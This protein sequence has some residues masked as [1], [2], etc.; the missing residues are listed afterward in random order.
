[1]GPG[2]RVENRSARRPKGKRKRGFVFDSNVKNVFTRHISCDSR[3]WRVCEV[4]SQSRQSRRIYN[5]R[6]Q[7]HMKDKELAD[8]F[9]FE[10]Q[11]SLSSKR[12]K[13]LFTSKFQQR[14]REGFHLWVLGSFFYN[15]EHKDTFEE[16]HDM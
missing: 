2:G 11:S 16:E 13:L 10:L 5:K 7:L 14:H 4:Y 1:M 8:I 9:R 12:Q 15:S 3:A 6:V